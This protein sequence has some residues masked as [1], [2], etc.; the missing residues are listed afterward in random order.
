[1]ILSPQ[2]LRSTISAVRS[3]LLYTIDHCVLLV[4]SSGFGSWEEAFSASHATSVVCSFPSTVLLT[5]SRRSIPCPYIPFFWNGLTISERIAKKF[6][7]A[8]AGV[9]V[10]SRVALSGSYST[11][12][13][14]PPASVM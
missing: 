11:T 1:M 5:A 7:T 14:S 9:A 2:C 6:V 12:V 3:E 8:S 4:T 10:K 13:P